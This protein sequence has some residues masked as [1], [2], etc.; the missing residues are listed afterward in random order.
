MTLAVRF[1]TPRFVPNI[2]GVETRIREISTRLAMKGF[3][4][5][6]CAFDA[7]Q[8]TEEYRTL[9][10]V[11]I[12]R[13]H[14]FSPGNAYY[15][16]GPTF[17]HWMRR[18]PVNITDAHNIH[19]LPALMAAL[20]HSESERICLTPHYHGEAHTP[21]RRLLFA[22]YKKLAKSIVERCDCIICVSES[23]RV[24]FEHDFAECRM[25]TIQNG[26]DYGELAKHPWNGVTEDKSLLYVGRLDRYK[27]VDILIR[28]VKLL[29]E[30][31]RENVRALIIGSGPYETPLH[32]LSAG[33]KLHDAVRWMPNVTRD[34]L[35]RLCQSA[36][37]FVMLSE[38][39]AYSLAVAD[40]IAQGLPTL[41]PKVGPFTSYVNAGLAEGVD[42]PIQVG[43]VAE[44]LR[45]MLRDPMRY[46]QRIKSRNYFLSWDDVT[47]DIEQTYRSLLE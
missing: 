41:V 40:A 7:D 29:R 21:F 32:D 14:A 38:H 31:F 10:G 36:T 26:V 8:L 5:E 27:N 28:A 43:K 22:G 15:V 17:C 11:R 12:H 18:H 16:P 1:V 39:E 9:E 4:V 47:I 2:G 23:E 24:L 34:E 45:E 46:S 3:E 20:C 13:F 35:L 44:K 30:H 25:T 6:V 19:A 37:I 42:A 33:L